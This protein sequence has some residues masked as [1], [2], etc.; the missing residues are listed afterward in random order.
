MERYALPCKGPGRGAEG[1][2]SILRLLRDLRAVLEG[3]K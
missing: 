3:L 1:A 2:Q